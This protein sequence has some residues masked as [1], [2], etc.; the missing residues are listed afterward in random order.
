MLNDIINKV[1]E[2]TGISQENAQT[3]VTT[4][5]D[6]LKKKLPAP[7]AS[8]IDTVLGG[9]SISGVSDVVDQAKDKASSV[10]DSAKEKLGSLF[11]KK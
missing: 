8:Q 6:F 1:A 10:I 7:I 11:N 2:K 4:V 5:L 3:A 9:G